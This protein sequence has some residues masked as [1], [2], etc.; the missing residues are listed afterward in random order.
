M[1]TEKN[2]QQRSFNHSHCF[3]NVRFEVKDFF[4]VMETNILW[5]IDPDF[6]C[7]YED[8]TQ[9]EVISVLTSLAIKL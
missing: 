4:F 1:N 8:V 7:S 6:A 9:F 5:I 2:L 3:Q